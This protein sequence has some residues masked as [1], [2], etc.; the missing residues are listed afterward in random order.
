RECAWRRA[1]V[2]AARRS[3]RQAVDMSLQGR[4]ELVEIGG[5]CGFVGEQI[6]DAALES[7]LPV[8]ARGEIRRDSVQCTLDAIDSRIRS[9]QVIAHDAFEHEL[10]V[11]GQGDGVRL[12]AGVES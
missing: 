12:D 3:E 7:K 9:K 5:E 11:G 4:E 10:C 6:L 1:P 2:K 8:P